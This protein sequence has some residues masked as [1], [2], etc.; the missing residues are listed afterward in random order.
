LATALFLE[1]AG[2]RWLFDSANDHA[3]QTHPDRQKSHIFLPVKCENSDKWQRDYGVF[4]MCR[5]PFNQERRMYAIMGVCAYGTQG[6][7]ALACN[8]DSAAEVLIAP[9]ASDLRQYSPLLERIAWVEV[10]NEEET[11]LWEFSD[12]KLRY[13]I[14]HPPHPSKKGKWKP[15]KNPSSIYET[16]RQLR[17]SLLENTL[18]LGAQPSRLVFYSVALSAAVSLAWLVFHVRYTGV[19]IVT[20]LVLAVTGTLIS[21]VYL[22]MPPVWRGHTNVQKQNIPE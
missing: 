15:H 16:Q 3:L 20:A 18:F 12:P 1:E 10:W 2:L 7:A 11:P 21:L 14:K 6:A 4:V 19:L 13:I 8:A 17:T 9:L 22:I 5:N